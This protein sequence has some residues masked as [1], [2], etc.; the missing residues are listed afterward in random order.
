MSRGFLLGKFM[1]PHDGHLMMCDFARA[2]C[3]ELTILVCTRL[4]EPIDG[5][6]RYAWM[7]ELCPWARVVHFDRD[8][9]QEPSEAPD[10]WDIW[11]ETDGAYEKRY[12]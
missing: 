6:L 4:V 8:V 11:R 2:Y 5:N 3:D 10:F 9:P 1:P 7:C 12:G